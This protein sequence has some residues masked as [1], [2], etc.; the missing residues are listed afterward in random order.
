MW[1]SHGSFR[2]R[3]SRR[4]APLTAALLLLANVSLGSPLEKQMREVERLRHLTFVHDVAQRTIDRREL[5]PLIRE[6]LSKS[7]PYSIEDYVSVLQALQLVDALQDQRFGATARD[8]ALQHDT[9]GELAYHSLLE[10][11]ATLVMLEYLLEKTGQSFEEAV[12]SDFLVSAMG[13][14]STAEKS[15]DA[16][17]PPY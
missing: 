2:M 5:R 15:I 16:S 1:C 10:G 12:K 13:A 11:E 6:Q 9:D 14:A 17:T 8:R 3:M 7:I 4:L